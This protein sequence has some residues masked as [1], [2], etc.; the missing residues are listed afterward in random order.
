[1][2]TVLKHQTEGVTLGVTDKDLR[3]VAEL[4][5]VTFRD[6]FGGMHTVFAHKSGP[7]TSVRDILT[8]F[9][10]GVLHTHESHDAAIQHAQMHGDTGMA[11]RLQ[12]LTQQSDQSAHPE[13]GGY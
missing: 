7:F 12:A 13:G 9:E 5:S 2:T 11:E 10:D 8:A 3:L 6:I 4:Q 1:M